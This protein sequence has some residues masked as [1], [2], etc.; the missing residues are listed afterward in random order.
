MSTVRESAEHASCSLSGPQ[1]TS[2]ALL[3]STIPPQLA[4]EPL[5]TQVPHT[6][7]ATELSHCS[8]IP[9]LSLKTT[10]SPCYTCGCI[11]E[12]F[13][14]QSTWPCSDKPCRRNGQILTSGHPFVL[15]TWSLQVKAKRGQLSHAQTISPTGSH[16]CLAAPAPA[17]G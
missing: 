10:V 5:E 14:A 4:S 13:Q 12:L 15:K 1:R 8:S 6:S 17:L 9:R 16:L 2:S 3:Y 7:A 11:L